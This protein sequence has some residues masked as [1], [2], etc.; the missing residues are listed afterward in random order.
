MFVTSYRY[1]TLHSSVLHGRVSPSK[2]TEMFSI[3]VRLAKR[4]NISSCP[5]MRGLKGGQGPP[6][7][8]GQRGQVGLP[9]EKRHNNFK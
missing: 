2:L 9:G 4:A 6:G 8:Q 1:I 5:D 3:S 7:L